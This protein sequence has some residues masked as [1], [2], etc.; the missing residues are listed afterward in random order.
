M[1]IYQVKG[2]RGIMPTDKLDYYNKIDM[3]IFMLFF[4]LCLE[5]EKLPFHRDLCPETSYEKGKI[6]TATYKVPLNII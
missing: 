5:H 3:G 6:L 4:E 1:Y 2:K